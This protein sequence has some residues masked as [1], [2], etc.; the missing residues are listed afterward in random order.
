[1][2]PQP[3]HS[4]SLKGLVSVSVYVCVCVCLSLCV[5]G[6]VNARERD[7]AGVCMHKEN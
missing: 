4:L 3:V 2:Q 7:C 1:M 5:L 6:G